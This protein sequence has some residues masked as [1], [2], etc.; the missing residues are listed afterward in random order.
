MRISMQVQT[1]YDFL[2]KVIVCPPEYMQI[3]ELINEIQKK[4][5]NSNIDIQK[6]KNQHLYF[7]NTLKKHH[8]DTLTL[9]P[10]EGLPEQ[11][12]ARDIG[13]MIGSR[14][15]I[16]KMKEIIRKDEPKIL[17]KFLQERNLS[18]E[19]IQ[20]GTIEGG[21][22]LIDGEKIFI[23]ISGRTSH[24]A[25]DELE[26]KLDFY[27]IFRIPIHPNFLHLDCVLNILSGGKA[28]I[29][30]QAFS[31]EILKTLQQSYQLL[32]IPV[33]EQKSLATN[34]LQIDQNTLISLTYNTK[35]NRLLRSN[36][37]KVIEVDITEIIKSGGSFR[38]ITLPLHREPSI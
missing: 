31:T 10:I 23:G 19:T 12:F 26:K 1:E 37:F 9:K 3:K 21:D 8:I 20:N 15:F 34:I 18:F 32:E 30:K 4:H 33:E 13:F 22:V 36:G 29:Y 27:K 16:A 17:E 2:N 7:V 11:V 25:V 38:C 14:F 6:A 28:L 24:E 35:T 5:W